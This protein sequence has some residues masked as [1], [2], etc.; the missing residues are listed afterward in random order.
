LKV[1]NLNVYFPQKKKLFKKPSE[2]FKAVDDVSFEIYKGEIVGLVGESGCGKTTLGRT[3]LQLIQPTSGNIILNGTNLA[4]LSKKQL[5]LLRKDVQIVF[6]D[7]Y[8]SLNPRLTI[9]AA[10][11]E[12]MKVH[13]LL[14]SD[15]KRKERVI[16]LLEKVNMD[17]SQYNQYPHQFSG[18]QRQRI[19]IARALSLNPSF[20]VFDESLSAL[21]VSIQAQ[22]LK[23]LND[24]K[25]EFGF[26]SIF[27]S[28]DLSIVH[29]ISDRIFVMNKG[30]IVEDGT[31]DKIYFSPKNEYTKKLIDS[32]PGKDL[33]NFRTQ[34]SS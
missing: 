16:E 34:Q 28:H 2:Y 10:I 26:T 1:E 15:N 22:V 20:L 3:I 6:Q 17:A 32:I 31:A 13:G 21:D 27:I 5:R 33:I 8:G 19:C 11:A 18:G 9:G 23:L 4:T 24:L 25:K 14:T 29:Y 7:P 12:P 30:K